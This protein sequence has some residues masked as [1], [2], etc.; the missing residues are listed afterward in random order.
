MRSVN[1]VATLFTPTQVGINSEQK[2]ITNSY[3]FIYYQHRKTKSLKET[4]TIFYILF[5]QTNHN[6]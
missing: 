5:K 2:R 1:V 3:L 4:E 6:E